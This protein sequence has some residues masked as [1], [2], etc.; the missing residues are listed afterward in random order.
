MKSLV[1]LVWYV[2]VCARV[3][4]TTKTEDGRYETRP[5][6][7]EKKKKAEEEEKNLQIIFARR[8]DHW[9]QNDYDKKK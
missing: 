6:R 2:C 5:E 3:L 4:S 8:T 9:C 7:T 1:L